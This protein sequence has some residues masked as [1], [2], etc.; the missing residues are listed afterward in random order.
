MAKARKNI[1]KYSDNLVNEAEDIILR[2]FFPEG[3]DKTIREIRERADYS[4]ERVY[5]YLKELMKKK[6]V[7]EKKVGKTLV[8]SLDFNN[9]YS[10]SAFRHY[11]TE[12][13]I[14]FGNKYPLIYRA[15]QELE[16]EPLEIVLIFGSYPKGTEN[17]NSDI[18]M[19]IVSDSKK[20]REK[21]IQS[22]KYKYGLNISPTFMPRLEFP[23]IKTENKELWDDIK[24][25]AL[26]FKGKSMFYYW[27]YKNDK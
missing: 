3:N 13:I 10:K 27:M 21:A 5:T 23:K 16:E 1:L 20:E 6:I 2:C 25:N 14:D 9:L 26:I 17:K 15:L 24:Q 22:L 18:D 12:R 19:I 11:M 4:Y 8:Y 7:S